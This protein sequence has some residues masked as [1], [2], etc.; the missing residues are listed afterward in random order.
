MVVKILGNGVVMTPMAGVM[1]LGY[2]DLISRF[3][4]NDDYKACVERDPH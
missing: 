2:I 1:S 4:Q 3:R